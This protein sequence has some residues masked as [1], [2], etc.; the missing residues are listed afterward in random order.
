MRE[1]V[2]G[3]RTDRRARQ[4]Y[5]RKAFWAEQFAAGA[6]VASYAMNRLRQ[7]PKTITPL[8]ASLVHTSPPR[9]K[10]DEKVLVCSL[11][12][13]SAE[14]AVF[15]APPLSLSVSPKCPRR[16]RGSDRVSGDF[17]WHPSAVSAL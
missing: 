2:N 10:K 17:A 9:P 4:E 14:T 13:R 8:W 16:F 5:R 6:K 11:D 12:S 7:R 1:C 15:P 3:K